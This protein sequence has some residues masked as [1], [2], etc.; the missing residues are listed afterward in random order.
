MATVHEPYIVPPSSAHTSTAILLHGRDDTAA[1]FASELFES[2]AS[3]K[4]TLLQI[5][6]GTKWVFPQAPMIRSETFGLELS[7]WFDMRSTEDPHKDEERQKEELTQ[8]LPYLTNLVKI[9]AEIVGPEQVVLGGISQGGATAIWALVCSG[10]RIGG[11]IGISTWLP[12]QSSLP[13][14]SLIE[15]ES[16]SAA[17]II[18]EIGVGRGMG[19]AGVNLSKVVDTPVF[20]GHCVD[21]AVIK[22]NYGEQMIQTLGAHGFGGT[23]KNY[24]SGGHWVNEPDGVD[25]IVAFLRENVGV[26]TETESQR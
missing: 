13:V 8:S 12:F 11:F 6:P 23:F 9:E 7:Q 26:M 22:V 3:D 21:D 14:M 17:G 1:E 4:R 18:G 19:G 24:E 16:G 10:L 20:I 25:D 15:T 2:Q 5:F